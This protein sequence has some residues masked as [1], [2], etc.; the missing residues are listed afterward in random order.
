MNKLII[1]QYE[2]NYEVYFTEIDKIKDWVI[3]KIEVILTDFQLVRITN[4]S[5]CERT[6]YFDNIILKWIR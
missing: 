6:E 5:V 1:L 3:N 4:M 2:N